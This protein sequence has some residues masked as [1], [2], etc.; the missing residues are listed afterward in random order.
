MGQLTYNEVNQ[1]MRTATRAS[2]TPIPPEGLN[3]QQIFFWKVKNDF[4]WFAENFLK[5]RTKSGELKPFVLN[6]AQIMVEALD[7]YCIAHNLPRRFVILKARQTGMSTYSE[8]KL[9]HQ[10]ITNSYTNSLVIAHDDRSSSA[11]FSM[12]K[13]YFDELHPV[14]KPMKKYSNEKLLHFEN[15]DENDINK[16]LRSSIRV[17]SAG[18]GEVGRGL[19]FRCVHT[20]ELAFFPDARTTMLALLQAVPDDPKCLVIYES[21]ANGIGDYFHTTWET[22]SKGESDILPIFLP[23]FSDPT[24]TKQFYTTEQR[25]NFIELVNTTYRDEEGRVVHTDEYNLMQEYDL[26]YEQLFWYDWVLKNKCNN[27]P[28][29]RSQEYP[30]TPDEAFLST[31]R[32]RFSISMLKK[33]RKQTKEPVRTGYLEWVN[34]GKSVKFI[35]DKFG[36]IKL[37]Q[38]PQAD[39]FYCIGADV[40]EGKASG[41]YSVAIV[42]DENFDCIASW[43]G[44]IDPDLFGEELVKFALYFNEAYLGIENNNHGLATLKAVQRLEYWNIYYTKTYDKISDQLSTKM[45]WSTNTRTKPMMIDK[46]AEFIREGY[47]GIKW[48]LLVSELIS[49]IIEDNGSTNAQTGCHDDTVMACA[50]L[51]QVLLEGRGENYVPETPHD[52]LKRRKEPTERNEIID[53]LFEQE[54]EIECT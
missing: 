12:T 3:K 37:W 29:Q 52:E 7:R 6:D 36:Y 27:D 42:G 24:Y 33:Y 11:L 21:T 13:L 14:V 47:I 39:K 25:E 53:D 15:P 4:A 32:P 20:S 19:T 8:A 34:R 2:I 16:G 10:T 45:G 30:S 23:W 46:L 22:S 26:T 35:E 43:Y 41:D 50:I 1:I 28:E 18:S 31:G 40:A 9:L 44:H 54:Q 5:I 51:L 48:D 49:Y 17:Q 38:E